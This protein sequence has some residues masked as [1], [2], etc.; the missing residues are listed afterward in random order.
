MR[1]I[2]HVISMHAPRSALLVALAVFL[3]GAM[4]WPALRLR[5][6]AGTTG[7]VLHRAT[8][9][10]HRFVSAALGAY[11]VGLVAWV[12]LY[13][14]AGA[15]ALGVWATPI[16]WQVIAFSL[17]AAGFVLMVAAQRQMGTSWRV[18]IDAERTPL[19]TGGL[20]GVTRNPI[21]AAGILAILGIAGLTPSPWTILGAAQAVLLVALQARLE[22]DH[23]ARMHGEAYRAYAAR[24]GRFWPGMG[25]L[26]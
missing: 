24:V 13:A 14:W 6:R 15:E 25:R 18:G 8:S 7:I 1:A 21:Y 16:E 2:A 22:E 5:A 17:L 4:L 3:F 26:V 9:T 11:V 12:V 19:V 10:V 20:F 23:L